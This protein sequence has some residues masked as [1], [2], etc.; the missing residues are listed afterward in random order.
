E[1]GPRSTMI[2]RF[3]I[4]TGMPSRLTVSGSA[5]VACAATATT[6][7]AMAAAIHRFARRGRRSPAHD[8]GRCI[9][10]PWLADSICNAGSIASGKRA[11]FELHPDGAR[12][13]PQLEHV[14]VDAV[15]FGVVER[16]REC[17]FERAARLS[18][19]GHA[20]H[21]EL[22]EPQR[23][24]ALLEAAGQ[25]IAAAISDHSS[26]LAPQDEVGLACTG[27]NG[28]PVAVNLHGS[29]VGLQELRAGAGRARLR[30]GRTG[31]K[32]Q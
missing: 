9:V 27:M 3:A 28:E 1:I 13:I 21:G 20:G 8:F 22:A 31:G 25:G 17:G 6:T 30:R 7:D 11:C 10:S 5:A 4:L 2:V 23:A 26:A 16:L 15:R 19:T 29:P 14:A 24:G 18:H 12:G 32:E